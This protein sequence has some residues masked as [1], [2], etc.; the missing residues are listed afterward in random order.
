MKKL[1]TFLLLF[2]LLLPVQISAKVDY[3]QLMDSSY[4]E[5]LAGHLP[6][7][8]K[9]AKDALE[10]VPSDSASLQCE[11][12]SALLYAYHRLGDYDQ[13]LRYGELCLQYD[14][15]VGDETNLSVSLGNLAGI[16][17]SAGKQDV[18]ETYL[19]QAIAIEEHLLEVDADHTPK[20][21]AVRKAMLGEVLVAQA[22]ALDGNARKT[23]LQEALRLTTDA[24]SIDRQL[25]RTQQVGMRLSQ[26]GKIYAELGNTVRAQEC[27]E[28]ALAIAR[29]IGNK[30]SEVITLL[31]MHRYVE[32]A[33][34]ANELGMRKQEAEASEAMGNYAR[35][36]AL[37]K[38]LHSE[39]L[40]RQLSIYQVR[41]DTQQKEQQ[42]AEQQLQIEAHKRARVTWTIILLL[43]L[44]LS[45][46][47][48]FY[49][50]LQRRHRQT[51]QREAEAK[52]KHYTILAHDLKNPMN[53]QCQVLAMLCD[54]YDSLDETFMRK[55]LASLL[56]GSQT[57]LELLNNLQEL[58]LLEI[59]KHSA[60]PV[61]FDALALIRE[62]I[63]YVQNSADLKQL[64]LVVEGER[65]LVT[66][67]R[68][69][70]RTILRNLLSNAIKF[71]HKGN[72]IEIGVNSDGEMYVR[73]HGVGMS[74]DRV[75]ELL[76][77]K[78]MVASRAGTNDEVGTGLGLLICKDL[79]ALNHGTFNITSEVGVGTTISVSFSDNKD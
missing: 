55:T 33:S 68:E 3:H 34:L 2:S 25:K 18:A 28:E 52:D 54:N 35:A 62:V 45:F 65:T 19:R 10:I 74:P 5:A 24:L 66:A 42:L 16:Y 1:Y 21:M 48:F 53:A 30:P 64:K 22:A 13:A 8:I 9:V 38:E 23:K 20:S 50:R 49:A 78:K 77:V 70:V 14:Q 67:D 36:Y 26:L 40:A 32:A 17:S 75:E 27:N 69:M 58:T 44:A 37:T 79:I 43:A 6:Q 31:Q 15:S 11:F 39:E 12:Y 71:S 73:D 7:A 60:K 61:R 47:V 46:S 59:G 63:P 56:S 29:E 51:I 4:N 41:Y 76:T 57:Q 72:N